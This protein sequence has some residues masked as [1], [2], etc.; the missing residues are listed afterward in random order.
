M[1]LDAGTD[2]H[3]EWVDAPWW[4]DAVAESDVVEC[5][6][7]L[8]A[9]NDL[10]PMTVAETLLA[11]SMAGAGPE[12]IRLLTTLRG[13]T[14]T[15]E[16]RLTVI[17]LWQPQ[18]GWLTGAEQTAIVDLVGPEPDPTDRKAVLADE[19]AP[20]ELAAALHATPGHAT[21]RIAAARLLHSALKATGDRLRAGSLDPYRV[22]LITDTLTSL[23]SHPTGVAAARQVEAEIL[24]RAASMTGGQ[25]RKA[26]RKGCR[27]VDPDWGAR[28][29]AKAR[30]TRRVGFDFR[31]Q[32]GLVTLYAALP[33]VEAL[34]VKD[35]LEQLAAVPSR[36]P[37][38]EGGGE[39]RCHDERM[40]DALVTAVLGAKP[41]DP[42]TPAAP[43]IVLQVL[44]PLP[45]LLGLRE[46]TAELVGYGDIP[47]GMAR[48]MAG[49]AAWELWIHDEL[50]GHLLDQGKHSY[51]PNA[52]LGRY[53]TNRDRY[54]RFP[55]CPR[56][57]ASCDKD[58][59]EPFDHRSAQDC[60]APDAATC[61]P[62]LHPGGSTSA[63]NLSCLCRRTHRA[64]TFGD[65]Q[66]RQDPDGT[67]HWITPLGRTYTTHPWDYRPDSDRD[68]DGD[69]DG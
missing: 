28:M 5:P 32:D 1:D 25:L 42:T 50:N 33:P 51:P 54:C 4:L 12:A 68:E 48:E 22:W 21:A 11:A 24:G 58:H 31:G 40:A 67:Q 20:H 30:K 34:A 60:R 18:V 69:G 39:E 45:T 55:G 63:A 36:T 35:R 37:P 14:L 61:D 19:F 66:T 27:A 2:A 64:K 44:V 47:A 46:D 8:A 65:Y 41:D 10:G 9:V 62:D 3:P 59:T 23:G 16:Q 43:G 53:I 38:G 56:P 7:L 49:D 15:E 26:L 29:F 17:E 57:A 13:Q 6:E 52:P